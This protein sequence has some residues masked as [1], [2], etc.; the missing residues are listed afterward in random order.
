[1]VGLSAPS[2]KMGRKMSGRRVGLRRKQF[3]NIKLLQAKSCIGTHTSPRPQISTCS[4]LP[5]VC[6]S[7][8]LLSFRIL[9][10]FTKKTG[11]V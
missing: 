3:S 10:L 9:K 6:A 2:T 11:V 1:M 4:T 5:S 7:V 8:Y